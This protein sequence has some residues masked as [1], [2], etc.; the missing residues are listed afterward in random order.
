[1]AENTEGKK[2]KEEG[3]DLDVIS[4]SLPLGVAF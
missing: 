1:M 2:R 4:I 3:W